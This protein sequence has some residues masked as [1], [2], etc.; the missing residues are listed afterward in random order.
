MHEVL[1]LKTRQKCLEFEDHFIIKPIQF[2]GQQDWRT[3]GS[4][5]SDD[6]IYASNQTAFGFP[7]MNSGFVMDF[8]QSEIS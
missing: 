2:L 4:P 8:I 3:Y 1:I 5:C 7:K 6:F